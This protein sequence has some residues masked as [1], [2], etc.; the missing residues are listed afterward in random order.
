MPT[1]PLS[2]APPR[3][4]RLLQQHLHPR[5]AAS[6][7]PR[8]AARSPSS[9]RTSSAASPRCRRR[10]ARRR[11]RR[12]AARRTHSMPLRPPHPRPVPARPRPCRPEAHPDL[13]LPETAS[14]NPEALEWRPPPSAAAVEETAAAATSLS[15][16]APEFVPAAAPALRRALRRRPGRRRRSVALGGAPSFVRWGRTRA[17]AR[18]ARVEWAMPRSSRPPAARSTSS[19]RASP[20][21]KRDDRVAGSNDRGA[22][23]AGERSANL[24]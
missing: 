13:S 2:D 5:R 23:G 12:G 3:T 16:D 22:G 15:I 9:R 19:P 20:R 21:P 24:I 10:R 17:R 11:R 1:T 14:L 7:P 6:S 4:P 8:A 18:W